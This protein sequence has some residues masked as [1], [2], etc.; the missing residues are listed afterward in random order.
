ML[1]AEGQA[2]ADELRLLM[3]RGADRPIDDASFHDLARRVFAYNHDHV[4][5]YAAYCRARGTGPSTATGWTDIP[6]VPTA[7]FKEV[8]LS[9]AGSSIERVFRTSGTTR[10]PERR[11]EHHVADLSLYR[12]SLRAAFAAFVLPDRPRLPIFSLV[13]GADELP[14]SSLAFMIEDVRAHFGAGGSTFASRHGV[15]LDGLGRAVD[16][17]T[18]DHRPILLVGTSAAFIHWLD[19]MTASGR[20]HRRAQPRARRPGFNAAPPRPSRPA[21]SARS[22]QQHREGTVAVGDEGLLGEQFLGWD[23]EPEIREAFEEGG[24]R[25]GGLKSGQ[26]CADAV[27][28]TVP[29]RQMLLVRTGDVERVGALAGG[30]PQA[31]DHGQGETSEQHAAQRGNRAFQLLAVRPQDEPA[32]VAHTLDGGLNGRP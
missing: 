19:R 9:A 18:A 2:L 17:A 25:D 31:R 21:R 7:A 3:E 29:E 22:V 32:G 20:R 16:A 4:P 24:Q 15:D 13:P 5:A 10:G 28:H 8:V 11:G 12:A 1:D 27:V 26:R 14:D 30:E 23:G 6:A